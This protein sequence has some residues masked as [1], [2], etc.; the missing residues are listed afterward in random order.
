SSLPD[1]RAKFALIFY[2][3]NRYKPLFI[4]IIAIFVFLFLIKFVQFFKF[5]YF[6]DFCQKNSLKLPKT[7]TFAV[8]CCQLLSNYIS[9]SLCLFCF[10]LSFF[11]CKYSSSSSSSSSCL[12]SLFL[13]VFLLVL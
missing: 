4:R 6:V 8:N 2:L 13:S 7:A 9:K 12:K 5:S 3:K 1:L 11:H 10:S